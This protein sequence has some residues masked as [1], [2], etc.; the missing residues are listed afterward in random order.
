MFCSAYHMAKNLGLMLI[1]S[2][3][4]LQITSVIVSTQ[5]V[6]KWRW[7][8]LQDIYH[9]LS[10]LRVVVPTPSKSQGLGNIQMWRSGQ[11]HQRIRSLLQQA[12]AVAMRFVHTSSPYLLSCVILRHEQEWQS[13]Q[14]PQLNSLQPDHSS[15]HNHVAHDAE[16]FNG[17]GE[18]L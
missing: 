16:E 12:V 10:Y 3:L 14:S 5:R 18:N 17:N 9:R 13:L 4:R 6:A 2:R 1:F 11:H 8:F 7:K 15:M